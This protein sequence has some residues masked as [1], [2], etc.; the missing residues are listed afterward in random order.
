MKIKEKII[1]KWEN[2]AKEYCDFRKD[3]LST[4]KKL[5]KLNINEKDTLHIACAIFGK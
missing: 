5:Q 4:G 3:I 1:Q 2:I